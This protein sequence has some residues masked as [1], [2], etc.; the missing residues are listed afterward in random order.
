MEKTSYDQ[1]LEKAVRNVRAK[2]A[3][4]YHAAIFVVMNLLFLAV[5]LM[6]SPQVIWFYWPLLGW[7]IGLGTHGFQ[8]FVL[9]EGSAVKRR[10]IEKE[11]ERQ[12]GNQM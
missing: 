5:N 6:Y 3:F 8:V 7:S 11:M 10:M 1:E 9:R 12:R 2:L 4:Y